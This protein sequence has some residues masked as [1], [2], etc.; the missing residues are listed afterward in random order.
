MALAKPL[1]LIF[2]VEVSQEPFNEFV[3]AL[4]N[5]RPNTPHFRPLWFLEKVL[6]LA[7]PVR[8]HSNPSAKDQFMLT[9]SWIALAAGA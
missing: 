7:L 2:D 3:K 1:K 5:I 4:F 9:P 8:F 6:S